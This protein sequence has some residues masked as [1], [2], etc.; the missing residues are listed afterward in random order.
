MGGGAAMSECVYVFLD[1]SGNLDFNT[2]GTRYFVLTSV[3]MKRPF[4]MNGALD[5]YKYDCLEYG[6][7]PER[8]HCAYDNK[9][10]RNRVFH[11][12]GDHSEGLEI[13]SLFVEKSRV[14]PDNR[15]EERFYPEM[16]GNLLR[17][18]LETPFHA[19]AD[20]IIVITDTIPAK[21][22]RQAIEKAVK[23]TLEKV[24]PQSPRHRILHHDS[25][26]HYGLQV[27]DY[28]CWAIFRKLERGD[29]SYYR[30]IER[31]V[32]SELDILRADMPH[33]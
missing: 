13:H 21:R 1:E 30:R 32:R 4:Q 22:R 12:I 31:A 24:L 9:Y 3:S 20:E 17:H 33:D 2:S 27:A 29:A 5:G 14:A 28:C 26:S 19:A 6:L 18:V 8:F 11:I 10:V 7:D 25:R 23:V 15:A 16:L